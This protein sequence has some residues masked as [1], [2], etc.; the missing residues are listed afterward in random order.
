VLI[1]AALGGNA[2]LRRGETPSVALQRRNVRLAVG[3]LAPLARAHPLVITHGNGPQVGALALQAA[4][5]PAV[6]AAPLDVLDAESEGMIGYLIEQELRSQL[7]GVEIATLLTQV[8]VDAED[9]ALRRATKP[10]GPVYDHPSATRLAAE[11]GWSIAR[12]GE[13]WR[14]VVPSPEPLEILELE[15][16]SSS[17]PAG[18]A[19]RSSGSRAERCRGSRAS[20]TRTSQRRC[21]PPSSARTRCCC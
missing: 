10:I 2:L 13:G 5:A 3:A 7:P 19:S 18:S 12:D 14:R 15:T 9:P 6:E 8:R 17:A 21:W 20:S 16:S 11:R 1:V 4:A